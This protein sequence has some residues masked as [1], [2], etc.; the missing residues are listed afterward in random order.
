M[1]RDGHRFIYHYNMYTYVNDENVS[2]ESWV[3]SHTN[4][5]AHTAPS[6]FPQY[7]KNNHNSGICISYFRLRKKQKS[8]HLN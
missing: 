3:S 7:Q 8:Y 6:F 5:Q 4:D 2:C 1:V